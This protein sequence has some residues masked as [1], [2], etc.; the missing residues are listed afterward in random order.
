M[1]ETDHDRP[2]YFDAYPTIA[3]ERDELGVL[4]VRLHSDGGPVRY[5]PQHHHDWVRAFVDIADDRDNRVMILTGT[6]DSFID[7]FDWGQRTADP[8]MWDVI[9]YE[10]KHLLRRLLDIEI[11]VIGVVNGAATIHAELALLSDVTLACETAI[12]QDK[13]HVLAGSV[14]GDG[15]Q[16]VWQELLGP[17][18]GRYF[19][20][21]G[22][23]LSAAEA[24]DLGVV[25]EVMPADELMPR[26]RELARG[27]AVRPVLQ[28]RY[29]RVVLTGRLKR[30][31]DESLGHGLAVEGLAILDSLRLAQLAAAQAASAD[32]DD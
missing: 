27:L 21:T 14:P 12:V 26:A 4:T 10:G 11:P 1:T 20:L 29:T 25:N 7:L 31:I 5:S 8:Q 30:L 16:V 18:R 22:Q 17:N 19:L 3:F 15:V 6:G 9:Y 24:L 2:S 13:A 32:Q 28:M 23:V